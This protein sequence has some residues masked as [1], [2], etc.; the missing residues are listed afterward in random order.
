MSITCVHGKQRWSRDI[1]QCHIQ[2]A[3]R[4]DAEGYRLG[5]H[6]AVTALAVQEQEDTRAWWKVQLSRSF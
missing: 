5:Y 2:L 4:V 3:E 1:K 6:Q